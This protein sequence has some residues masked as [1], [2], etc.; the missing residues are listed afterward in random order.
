MPSYWVDLE[1][2]TLTRQQSGTATEF[3]LNLSLEDKPSLEATLRLI[4]EAKSVDQEALN[5]T[6][7]DLIKLIH[8][9]GT[10]ETRGRIESATE[11]VQSIIGKEA[12]N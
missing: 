5:N 12:N 4:Q 10:D 8:H 6:F 7:L 3:E 2:A 11:Y 9:F 1:S